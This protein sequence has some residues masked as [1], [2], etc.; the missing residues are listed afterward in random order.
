[1][2]WV[3]RSAWWELVTCDASHSCSSKTMK[4]GNPPRMHASNATIHMFRM[5]VPYDG[6][7]YWQQPRQAG[8]SDKL[9]RHQGNSVCRA[10]PLHR[11]PR[12]ANLLLVVV[13][14]KDCVPVH[15]LCCVLWAT[16]IT[17]PILTRK[18]HQTPR[19]TGS[20][21]W[22]FEFLD[23][24]TR[25]KSISPPRPFGSTTHTHGDYVSVGTIDV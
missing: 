10:G 4:V 1:V 18:T 20:S 21:Y 16:T 9:N 14:L 17:G 12:T 13:P 2:L 5:S 19:S 23:T 25:A 8:P 11:G 15:P 3:L 24:P 7:N 6:Q 22:V